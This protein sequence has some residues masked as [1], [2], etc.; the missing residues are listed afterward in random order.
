MDKV[1]YTL[2][3]PVQFTPTRRVEELAFKTDLTVRDMR[4][5]DGQQGAIASGATLL[6]LLS[7][8]PI[9]LIDALSAADFLKAQEMLAPFLKDSLGTGGN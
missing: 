5:L 9:E 3:T 2:Q 6:S 1:T 7:G 4:R 8:E